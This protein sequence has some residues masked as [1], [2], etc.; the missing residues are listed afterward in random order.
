MQD[1]KHLRATLESMR[2]DVAVL[3]A[4]VAE[5]EANASGQS[6]NTA[7]PAENP[8]PNAIS[9]DHGLSEEPRAWPLHAEEYTRYGRQMI[10]PEI[11]LEGRLSPS[12]NALGKDSNP[13]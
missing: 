3:E 8:I 4:R 13:A 11:G 7:L 2:A 9:T 10:I 6:D 12:S 1:V 5:A